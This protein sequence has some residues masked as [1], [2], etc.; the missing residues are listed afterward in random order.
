MV[1]TA[2]CLDFVLFVGHFDRKLSLSNRGAICRSNHPQII[3][4]DWD[5]Q[6]TVLLQTGSIPGVFIKNVFFRVSNF[7]ITIGRCG[8]QLS[9]S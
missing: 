6:P 7:K 1:Q 5:I 8:L 4:E 3:W 9:L 2:L